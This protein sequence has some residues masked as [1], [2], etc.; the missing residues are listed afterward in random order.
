MPRPPTHAYIGLFVCLFAVAIDIVTQ[1]ASFK[2]ERRH[3]ISVCESPSKSK[4]DDFPVESYPLENNRERDLVDREFVSNSCGGT[5]HARLHGD[6][7]EDKVHVSAACFSNTA[8]NTTLTTAAAAATMTFDL[9]MTL[10]RPWYDL[11]T[12]LAC[13]GQI[14]C[15][16]KLH[17]AKQCSLIFINIKMYT[18]T[19]SHNRRFTNVNTICF[20]TNFCL[21]ILINQCYHCVFSTNPY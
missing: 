19:F 2:P 16:C 13:Q 15:P 6:G 21:T 1:A 18:L 14:L 20:H 8:H 10:V 17:I 4:V 11:G 7:F 9:G 5:D 3:S 12:T